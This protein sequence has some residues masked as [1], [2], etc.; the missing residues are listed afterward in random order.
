MHS[1]CSLT[2]RKHLAGV[3]VCQVRWNFQSKMWQCS[4][5]WFSSS[6]VPIFPVACWLHFRISNSR[7]LWVRWK[8]NVYICLCWIDKWSYQV[9]QCG[10]SDVSPHPSVERIRDKHSLFMCLFYLWI[11]SNLQQ[12]DRPTMLSRQLRSLPYAGLWRLARFFTSLYAYIQLNSS[13]TLRH[14]RSSG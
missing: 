14:G 6:N 4:L 9:V 5:T 13:L 11:K 3:T 2:S 12:T 8:A 1:D 7:R 10:V